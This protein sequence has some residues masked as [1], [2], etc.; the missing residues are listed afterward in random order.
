VHP[1]YGNARFAWDIMIL[2]L[3]E[4]STMPLVKLNPDPINTTD[5]TNNNLTLIGFGDVIKGSAVVIP[6]FLQEVTLNYVP[7]YECNEMYGGTG[8]IT[9]DMLCASAPGKD[10]W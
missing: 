1:N 4:E 8:V 9:D 10:S 3:E 7:F 5:Y 2:K 6:T